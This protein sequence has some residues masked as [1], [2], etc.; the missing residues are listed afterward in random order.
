MGVWMLRVFQ[1]DLNELTLEFLFAFSILAILGPHAE[2]KIDL[3]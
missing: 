3:R 1:R 2:S